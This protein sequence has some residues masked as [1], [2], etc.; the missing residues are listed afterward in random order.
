MDNYTKSNNQAR[1]DT[2]KAVKF[3]WTGDNVITTIATDDNNFE[4][5]RI[6]LLYDTRNNPFRGFLNSDCPG[7]FDDDDPFL[8]P[9]SKNNIVK[10]QLPRREEI[11]YIYQY[12]DDGFPIERIEKP[13]DEYVFY[14][15]E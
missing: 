9:Y 11:A 4:L 14:E 1:G 8:F 15:Y 7:T 13:N 3:L 5:W 6:D 10:V 2:P 12:D